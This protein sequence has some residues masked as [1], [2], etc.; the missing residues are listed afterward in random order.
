[1]ISQPNDSATELLGWRL[2]TVRVFSVLYGLSQLFWGL[3]GLF[4]P[5]KMV[6]W[7]DAAT[8]RYLA[9][10]VAARNLP[11]GLA[12]VALATRRWDRIHGA[13]FLYAAAVQLGD[14]ILG[15]HQLLHGG[16]ELG[17]A[18]A[19]FVISILSLGAAG[20]LLRKS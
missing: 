9:G 2:I 5:A 3:F 13:F 1:M 18:I 10:Y 15:V 4:A 20:W 19:P 14:A 11:M 16:H 12:M 8:T 17:Q 6:P 7:G